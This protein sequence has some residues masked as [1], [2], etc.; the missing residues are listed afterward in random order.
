M[1]NSV[2][3]NTRSVM[4]MYMTN[5]YLESGDV[6]CSSRVPYTSLSPG[7]HLE[8][9]VTKVAN[10]SDVCV[11]P[12]GTELVDLMEKLGFVALYCILKHMSTIE[13]K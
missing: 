7:Q 12:Y 6:L 11:Q 10:P 2:H 13:T 3:M 9:L 8:V 1:S 4:L 5:N